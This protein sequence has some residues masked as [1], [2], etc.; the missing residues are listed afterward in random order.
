MK[1]NQLQFT[2]LKSMLLIAVMLLSVSWAQAANIY[3]T[4][5]HPKTPIFQKVEKCINFGY[6]SVILFDINVNT[7]ICIL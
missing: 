3:I 2:K 5:S 4:E 6:L 7:I 1:K